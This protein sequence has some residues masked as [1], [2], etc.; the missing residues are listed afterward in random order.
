MTLILCTGNGMSDEQYEDFFNV[1]KCPFM[2]C[3]S[4]WGLVGRGVCINNG[5]FTDESCEQ[6]VDEEAWL[7]GGMIYESVTNT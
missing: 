5:D 6:F 3:T 4:K 1:V 7:Q 2:E